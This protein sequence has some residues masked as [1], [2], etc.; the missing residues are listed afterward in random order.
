MNYELKIE[1]LEARIA[2]S[3]YGIE[4]LNRA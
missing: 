3:K 1:Q 2:P 4:N